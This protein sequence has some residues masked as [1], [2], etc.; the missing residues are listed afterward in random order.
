MSYVKNTWSN[1]D[2]ITDVKLNH[3]EDGIA[4]GATALLVTPAMDDNDNWVF[5]KTWQEIYDAF[6]GGVNVIIN[7]P[8]SAHWG[9]VVFMTRDDYGHQYSVAYFDMG[10][11]SHIGT[12][13]THAM[14]DY[15]IIQEG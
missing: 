10:I 14:N 2:V 5:D 4:S 15:P 13:L 1:G 12:A 11:E 6:F 3:M 8:D 9:T 7:I